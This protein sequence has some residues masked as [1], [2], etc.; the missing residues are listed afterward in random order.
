M[1]TSRPIVL[2]YVACWAELDATQI[3]AEQLTHVNYA[4]ACIRDGLVVNFMAANFDR[5]SA[6]D[7]ALA[8]LG[9]QAACAKEDAGLELIRRLKSAHPL[10]KAL[11]SVGG[12][13]AEGFSDA[14]LTSESRERFAN[15]AVEFMLRHGFD[16]VDL[17]WEYPC[18]TLAGIKA[19]PEDRENFSALLRVLRQKLDAQSATDGR[20]ASERYLLSIATGA[21]PA[22][23]EGVDIAAVAPELDFIGL[24]TYDLY[25][26]WSTRAGHHAN[27]FCSSLDPEGDS[28]AKAVDLF[29]QAGAPEAKLLL[30]AAFYGRGMSGVGAENDGL[31]QPS[32]PGSNFT[33]SYDEI[34]RALAESNQ[35]ARHWDEQAQAPFLYDGASFLS[36]EDEESL[37]SKARYIRERGLGG[38]MFWEYS[39]NRSGELLRA[40][41]AAL[42]ED[43]R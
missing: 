37:R 6:N 3:A 9:Y 34:V 4:F 43:R 32:T 25:N 39:N 29:V 38:A 40:L 35:W 18:S 42:S 8:A 7:P 17:D 1:S 30:G 27:L 24:M 10:L 2:A 15:S 33:R 28:A 5:L 22:H 21:A 11:I 20:G 36:Y 19:R 12:W 31:M 13:A 16:G 14:A 26:G 23:L 41:A